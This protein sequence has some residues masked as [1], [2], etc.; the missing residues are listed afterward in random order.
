MKDPHWYNEPTEDK[1]NTSDTG[2]FVRV[3][4]KLV[5]ITDWIFGLVSNDPLRDFLSAHFLLKTYAERDGFQTLLFDIEND[6]QE[7]NNIAKKH[8]EIVKDMLKDI[9]HYK[10]EIPKSAPYWMVTD[11]W[12]DTFI[13][14]I[15]TKFGNLLLYNEYYYLI[16]F[17]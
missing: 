1:I 5:R 7:T 17:L 14:G 4:E 8:P 9:E 12:H 10:T 3:I 15:S 16:H 6:P 13:T 2:L 11:N